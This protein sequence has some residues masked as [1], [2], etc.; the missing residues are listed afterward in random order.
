MK[1][2]R[3]KLPDGSMVI[4]K[5]DPFEALLANIHAILQLQLNTTDSTD[6]PVISKQAPVLL[7]RTCSAGAKYHRSKKR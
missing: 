3:I 2:R 6:Q 7:L 4:P 1:P 5:P